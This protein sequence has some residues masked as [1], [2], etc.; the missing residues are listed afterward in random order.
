MRLSAE[1]EW[2]ALR[3]PAYA[4]HLVDGSQLWDPEASG[5]PAEA[6]ASFW[7][8]GTCTNP[9]PHPIR[10]RTPNPTPTPNPNP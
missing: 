5:T 1:A 8:D 6:E 9:H 7:S 10:T 3:L 2:R 4:A